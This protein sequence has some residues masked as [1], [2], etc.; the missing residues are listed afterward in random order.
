M[1][2]TN[3]K[4]VGLYTNE[5]YN[6]SNFQQVVLMAGGLGS[7]LAPLTAECPKPLLTVG[8]QPVLETIIELYRT[9]LSTVCYFSELSIEMTKIFSD[10]Q[11]WDVSIEYLRE[12]EALGTAGSLSLLN[13]RLI[14][15]GTS[16]HRNEWRPLDKIELPE[17]T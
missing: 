13:N 3:Q 14:R 8:H 12:K 15:F 11:Q 7:R 1:V 2:D 10:G 9:W 17:L 6:K 5:N 4:V 16:N